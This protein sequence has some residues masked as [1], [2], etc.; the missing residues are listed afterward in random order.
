MIKEDIKKD[1]DIEK[2]LMI[3]NQNRKQVIEEIQ[4]EIIEEKE[5][6][7]MGEKKTEI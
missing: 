4:E 6:E 2:I 5:T 3:M 1:K 7:S